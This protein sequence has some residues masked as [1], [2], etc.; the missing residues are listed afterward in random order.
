MNKNVI[1]IFA[2]TMALLGTSATRH[3]AALP[4][5]DSIPLSLSRSFA[6][7]DVAIL[8]GFP[9]AR[10]VDAIAACSGVTGATGAQLVQQMYDTQS[11]RPGMVD[12]SGPHC[13]DFL[14]LGTPTFNTFPRRCPTP[15]SKLA[16]AP[17]GVYD[18]VPLALVNRFDMAPPDGANCG[19]YRMIYVTYRPRKPPVNPAPRHLRSR[20]AESATGRRHRRMPRRRAVLGRSLLGRFDERAPRPPRALFLRRHRRLRAG[21]IPT[22]TRSPRAAASAP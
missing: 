14:I 6:V 22:T 16:A 9:F 12:P 18:Y 19:Q 13:D 15:E 5:F 17:L 1:A 10:V 8:Q 21:V 20:A 2:V 3:R 11:P 4:P 7:T